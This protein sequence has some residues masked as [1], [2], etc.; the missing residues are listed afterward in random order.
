[1]I[2]RQCGNKLKNGADF[3]NKCGMPTFEQLGNFQAPADS[4]KQSKSLPHKKK[5]KHPIRTAVSLILVVALLAGTGYLAFIFEGG[6]FNNSLTDITDFNSEK[7]F[8]S[9]PAN[10]TDISITN[11]ASAIESLN[12]VKNVLGFDDAKNIFVPLNDNKIDDVSYYRLAQK[13]K[14][15]PVYGRNMVAIASR[16]GTAEGLIG[17]YVDVTGVNTLPVISESDAADKATSYMTTEHNCKTDSVQT[18]SQGLTIYTFDIG[19]T[20]CWSIS[21]YGWENDENYYSFNVLVNAI[22][23]SILTAISNVLYNQQTERL[24]GQDGA[25]YDIPFVLEQ[26]YGKVIKDKKRNIEIYSMGYKKFDIEKAYPVTVESNNKSAVDA[27]GN[28]I[29]TYDFFDSVL[30]RKQ[31]NGNPDTVLPVYVN[32]HGLKNAYFNCVDG[33][34]SFDTASAGTFGEYSS[35]LDIV[36]HEFTHGV[37]NNTCRLLGSKPES[38]ALNEAFSDIYGEIVEKYIT[39]KT[40]WIHGA[41]GI[42]SRDMSKK[43]TYKNFNYKTGADEHA[44]GEIINHAAYLIGNGIKTED[45]SKEQTRFINS[46]HADRDGISKY[47][48]LWYGVQLSLPPNATYYQCAV[49]TRKIA[50]IM[51]NKKIIT[52]AQLAGVVASFDKIG[53]DSV[54]C[55]TPISPTATIKVVDEKGNPIP[56]YDL[57]IFA[58][59]NLN[60]PAYSKAISDPNGKYSLNLTAG[61]YVA[62]ITDMYGEYTSFQRVT[63]TVAQGGQKDLTV[64]FWY[65][66]TVVTPGVPDAGI[67]PGAS[68]P[69]NDTTSSFSL[70]GDWKANDGGTVSFFADGTFAFE[71][72]DQNTVEKGTY[73]HDST[74]ADTFRIEM[75]STGNL[76]MMIDQGKARYRNYHLEIWKKSNDSISFVQVYGDYTAQNSDCQLPLTRQAAKPTNFS[77]VKTYDSKTISGL[78]NIEIEIKNYGK[79]FLELD[80]DTA[81]ITV[82]NFLNLIQSGFY[83]GLTF[84][85]IMAG[86]WI[87][88]GDPLGN[89]FGGSNQKITGEFIDNGIKNNISHKRGVISMAHR[90]DDFNSATS[91]FFIV[92]EDSIFLDGHQAGFGHVTSGMEIVDKIC[93]KAHVIDDNGSVSPADRPII[94]SIKIVE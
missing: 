44:N 74:T 26:Q 63:F 64:S 39:G 71:W 87:Q 90:N 38:H 92:H 79:I 67:Q 31:Y 21:A 61:Q 93:E 46:D 45:Y 11:S 54:E 70:V 51:K 57:D 83:N 27:M 75:K 43:R 77:T 56:R 76:K 66:P 25:E 14:D 48:K 17:N 34:I 88:G 91:Q 49:T 13:H 6:I 81:P 3:C 33:C 36:A 18:V 30:E 32:V 85:R 9:F 55:V 72:I 2:C 50:T 52:E 12:S 8:I 47:A 23:G 16:H 15:I 7:D 22:E 73:S 42:G 19:A 78:F 35:K 24:K 58:L 41:G 40:D 80:S 89:G 4:S 29:S 1:M 82:A 37:T 5:K 20:L 59:S 69:A 28:L 62:L 10:F 68:T 60:K 65:V 94:T 86:Y 53:V 84:H